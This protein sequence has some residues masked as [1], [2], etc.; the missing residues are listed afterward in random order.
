MLSPNYQQLNSSS[1]MNPCSDE[2]YFYKLD[3]MVMGSAQYLR[4]IFKQRWKIESG[5][6]WRDNPNYIQT[7][8]DQ[9]CESMLK[10]AIP[11]QKKILFESCT[12]DDWDMSMMSLVLL[13][14]GDWKKYK[15]QN[16]AIRQLKDLRNDLAH[17][18]SKRLKQSE[19]N[20]KVKIFKDSL[21]TLQ[22]KTS[23]IV[24]L[25]KRSSVS[26]SL[27]NTERLENMFGEA[28]QFMEMQDF[29]SALQKYSVAIT[30]PHLSPDNLREIYEKRAACYLSINN[31]HVLNGKHI[32]QAILDVQEALKLNK[33]SWNAQ[34]L[35]AK[36]HRSKNNLNEAIRYFEMAL[37]LSPLQKHI[38][39]DLD[40]C[41]I[42]NHAQISNS[43]LNP[44]NLP[45]TVNDILGHEKEKY[46]H[47]LTVKNFAESSGLQYDPVF[48]GLKYHD[49]WIDG[50]EV[51]QDYV[52]AA[53]YFAQ[54]DE[55]GYADG[56]L[57]L[58]ICYYN[59]HGVEQDV[60]KALEIFRR[61]AKMNPKK[62]KQF[63]PTSL[64]G[65]NDAV[66]SA[67][68]AIGHCF[69]KG[70]GVEKNLP[71]A[72]FWYT[73]AMQHGHKSA[74]MRLGVLYLDGNGLP[75]NA[76]MAEMCWKHGLNL[77]STFSAEFLVQYY[78]EQFELEMA[79]VM[80]KIAKEMGSSL[81]LERSYEDFGRTLAPM[82]PVKCRSET[83]LVAFE[84]RNNFD[85]K[86]I[87]FKQ[88]CIRVKQYVNDIKMS[89][90]KK[91]YSGQIQKIS[92]DVIKAVGIKGAFIYETASG[93]L[94]TMDCVLKLND[95]LATENDS[96]KMYK[97]NVVNLFY[98]CMM[99]EHHLKS[100]ITNVNKLKQIVTE[101]FCKFEAIGEKEM[102]IRLCYVAYN[103]CPSWKLADDLCAFEILTEGIRRYPDNYGYIRLLINCLKERGLYKD[104]LK[105][106]NKALKKYPE[107]ADLYYFKADV[108]LN[109]GSVESSKIIAAFKLFREKAPRDHR[110]VPKAFY[111]ISC[112]Y[113]EVYMKQDL[114]KHPYYINNDILNLIEE[115]FKV[116]KMR[117]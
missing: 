83:G 87:S 96:S 25:V 6:E 98:E 85:I 12:C 110:F 58:G 105:C 35:M 59:G 86:G 78:T 26:S 53:K 100:F 42:L 44:D 33:K 111:E 11:L 43:Q 45:L 114:A 38:R 67:E 50:F 51:G 62:T 15:L 19:Y 106:V 71:K 102:K 107:K 76:K 63:E 60:G 23:E 99:L 92:K 88:R 72:A 77:G 108:L 89:R 47:I 54:A 64:M 93:V 101:L 80:F 91:N 79:C 14:F 113:M 46:G 52:K 40:S 116:A 22:I 65:Y 95:L 29:K 117:K 84:K 104:A 109:S 75:Q 27:D 115:N 32:D 36:C 41:K 56:T 31:E 74:S 69:E 28:E 97:L 57:Q 70:I 94:K 10:T 18:K 103:L 17:H 9:H 55:Q 16:E 61:C 21:Q 7:F 4:Q 112:I 90:R 1:K 49:G 2:E 24:K 48:L 37:A 66:S 3:S 13:N 82:R 81:F 20:E 30:L 34:Y 73:K 5:E 68:N 39:R 8:L